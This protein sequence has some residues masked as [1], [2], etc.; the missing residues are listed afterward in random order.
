MEVKLNEAEATAII[1]AL[2]PHAK[3]LFEAHGPS[4]LYDVSPVVTALKAVRRAK[5]RRA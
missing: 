4:P 1:N 2:T 3:R 5:L